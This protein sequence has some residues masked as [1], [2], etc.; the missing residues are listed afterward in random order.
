LNAT[1]ADRVCSTRCAEPKN[2][3]KTEEK[4]KKNE[5]VIHILR[6]ENVTE[7]FKLNENVIHLSVW[8]LFRRQICLLLLMNSIRCFHLKSEDVSNR[9]ETEE[10]NRFSMKSLWIKMQCVHGIWAIIDSTSPLRSTRR[11]QIQCFE[12]VFRSETGPTHTPKLRCFPEQA[13]T[14]TVFENEFTGSAPGNR[15][16]R[17]S[18]QA[19][20]ADHNEIAKKARSKILK[21]RKD[22]KTHR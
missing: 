2:M 3:T 19:H 18:A 11:C 22:K 8:T 21:A 16:M 5:K 4:C 12:S 7:S 15:R 6:H 17:Q 13:L 14:T 1:L 20:A 10:Q 9:R